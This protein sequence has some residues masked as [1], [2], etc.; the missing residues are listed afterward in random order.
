[1]G[2]EDFLQHHRHYQRG[3]R[4]TQVSSVSVQVRFMLCWVGLGWVGL[5]CVGCGCV[6]LCCVVLC[7]IN[8][9]VLYIFIARNFDDNAKLL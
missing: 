9:P 2:S 8:L 6:V 1:M 3:I 7:F 4:R 5:G